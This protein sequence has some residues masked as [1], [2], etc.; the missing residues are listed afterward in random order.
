MDVGLMMLATPGRAREIAERTQ[1]AGFDHL[2]LAD[3]QNMGPEV[4]GQLML[5]AGASTS[6]QLGT[7]VTNP[8]TRDV[9]VTASAALALQAESDGRAYCGIGRGDSALA[10]IGGRPAKVEDFERSL[11][12][13]RAYLDGESTARGSVDSQLEW[14]IDA[15]LPRV[16][17]EVAAAGP[18]VIEVA[19]RHADVIGFCVGADPAVLKRALGR[20]RR[21]AEAAGRE[22]DALRFGAYLNCVVADDIDQAC[23]LARGGASVFARFSGWSSRNAEV[24]GRQIATE[25]KMIQRDYEMDHH[26]R[27]TGAGAE[28][29]DDAFLKQFAILGPPEHVVEH[30]AALADLG[31]DSATLA[32]GSSDMG[33]EEGWRSIE[34]IGGEVIPALSRS[35]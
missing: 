1:A 7:G 20:A 10:K 23:N 33:W 21:A 14:A 26:A 25:A 19:A 34:R 13:L 28:A 24:V 11:V 22:P 29:I 27:A 5:C 8:V 6:L 32:P 35:S 17:I 15:S 3:T 2:A 30:L 12:Q 16:P 4:W 31:L 9:A 18:R